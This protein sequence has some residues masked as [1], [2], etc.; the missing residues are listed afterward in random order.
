MARGDPTDGAAGKEA[1]GAAEQPGAR[2]EGKA[3]AEAEAEA[4]AKQSAPK[5]RV[6]RCCFSNTVQTLERKCRKTVQ[7]LFK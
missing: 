6:K 7:V 1:E 5:K 3:E 4:R 2:A